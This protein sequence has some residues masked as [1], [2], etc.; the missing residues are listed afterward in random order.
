MNFLYFTH[1]LTAGK[2]KPNLRVHFGEI[3]FLCSGKGGLGEFFLL[4][5]RGTKNCDNNLPAQR[6]FA[7]LCKMR[8]SYVPMGDQ[9]KKG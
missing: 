1:A 6:L 2:T 8:Y 5:M 7:E 9:N 3:N 4:H